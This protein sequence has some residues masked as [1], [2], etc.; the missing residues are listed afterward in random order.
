MIC[1]VQLNKYET[2][3][4]SFLLNQI[5]K[6]NFSVISVS[7]PKFD[8]ICLIG[9]QIQSNSS[10]NTEINKQSHVKFWFNRK[11]YGAVSYLFS[12]NKLIINNYNYL[13]LGRNNNKQQPNNNKTQMGLSN[14]KIT[15]A[16]AM[17]KKVPLSSQ[18]LVLK[19]LAKQLF[20]KPL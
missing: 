15:T 13:F 18:N 5:L 10:K 6:C 2:A 11:K 14:S 8:W 12:C 1:S 3:P 9:S 20:E 16:A 7:S 19:K 17:R 4:Y